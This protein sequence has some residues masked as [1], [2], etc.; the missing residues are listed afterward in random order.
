MK[1][2][3]ISAA[4]SPLFKNFLMLVSVSSEED[5]KPIK[6]LKAS[7]FDIHHLASLNHAHASKRDIKSVKEGPDGFYIVQ[8]KPQE[9][10]PTLPDGH[11]VFA[12]S[13]KI[14]KL[15]VSQEGAPPPRPTKF[16]FGQTI[17]VGDIPA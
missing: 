10:Q 5:G 1:R 8:L 12:V 3:I 15:M 9:F 17:A 13:V 7:N 11:Y 4:A 16:D 14:P 2:L 6:K